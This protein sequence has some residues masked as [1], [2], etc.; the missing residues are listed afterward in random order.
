M[1]LFS[2]RALGTLKSHFKDFKAIFKQMNLFL[3]YKHGQIVK[4]LTAVHQQ[5]IHLLEKGLKAFKTAFECS[6]SS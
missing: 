3:M 1:G 6:K 4:R 2:L 5:K